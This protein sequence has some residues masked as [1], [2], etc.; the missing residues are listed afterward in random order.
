MASL[1]TSPLVQTVVIVP[2]GKQVASGVK[3]TFENVSK[4]SL[5]EFQKTPNDRNPI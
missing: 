4:C 2:A 3:K 1:T 5:K